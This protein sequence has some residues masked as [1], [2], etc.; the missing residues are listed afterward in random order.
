MTALRDDVMQ[1]RAFGYLYAL[2]MAPR[3]I[4]RVKDGD[5]V[6]DCLFQGRRD[7]PVRL[8]GQE[9]HAD[10]QEACKSDEERPGCVISLRFSVK[11]RQ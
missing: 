10:Q 2:A 11:K 7:L 4:L 5:W 8:D 1:V 3:T 6:A 9:N